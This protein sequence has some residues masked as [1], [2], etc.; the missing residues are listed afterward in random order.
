MRLAIRPRQLLQDVSPVSSSSEAVAIVGATGAGKTTLINLL[1]LLRGA[2][3]A[4]THHALTARLPG[5][6]MPARPR[7]VSL[8]WCL[9]M[10]VLFEGIAGEHRLAR[11]RPRHTEGGRGGECAA[12]VD[13]FR[14]HTSAYIKMSPTAVRT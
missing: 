9:G 5:S 8:A 3:D 11:G 10:R 2:A 13:F 14:A 7:R 12:H 1:M 6:G 4:V